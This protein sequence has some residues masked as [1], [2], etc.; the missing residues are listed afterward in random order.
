MKLKSKILLALFALSLMVSGTAISAFADDT[1]LEMSEN[2]AAL[3]DHSKVLEYFEAGYYLNADFNGELTKDTAL[4]DSDENFNASWHTTADVS[5]TGT[6]ASWSGLGNTNFDFTSDNSASFGINASFRLDSQ[7]SILKLSLHDRDYSDTSELKT[8]TLVSF[9][10]GAISVY[11]STY[12]TKEYPVNIAVGAYFSFTAFYNAENGEFQVYINGSETPYTTNIGAFKYT[13]AN[14]RSNNVSADYLEMYK[15]SFIR[16]LSGNDGIIANKILELTSLYN[17]DPSA[18]GAYSYL[19]IITK[20]VVYHSF[21]IDSLADDVKAD[22]KAAADAAIK[23]NAVDYAN[24]FLNSVIIDKNAPYN[25]RLALVDNYA[26]LNDVL[27]EVLSNEKFENALAEYSNVEQLKALVV[28]FEQEIQDLATDAQNTKIAVEALFSV[29]DV[30]LANYAELRE[31]YDVITLHPLNPTYYDDVLTEEDVARAVK[32]V[33]ALNVEFTNKDSK[34]KNFVGNM[35]IAID[36]SKPFGERYDAYLVAKNNVFVD[37]SYDAY[38]EGATV[39]E[40]YDAYLAM[41]DSMEQTAYYCDA[42]ISKVSLASKMSSFSVKKSVLDEAAEY[43]IY[44]N[45]TFPGMEDALALYNAIR[46]EIKEK[47]EVTIKYIEAVIAVRNAE[48]YEAKKAAIAIAKAYELD[49]SD[50]SVGNAFVTVGDEVIDVTKANIILSDEES[51]IILLDTRATNYVAAVEAI[52]SAEGM[53]ARRAAINRALKLKANIES[54]AEDI[55]AATAILDAAVEA[56]NADVQTLNSGAN[57]CNKLAAAVLTRSI[58][59]K[60][61]AEVAAIIKKF[62]E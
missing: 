42:F 53:V 62:Y 8:I 52:A 33:N 27:S 59:A 6:T 36:E 51:V 56:Y 50:V 44:I 43:I 25:T 58:P 16:N 35:L 7:D 2:S 15:G 47:I 60:R 40:L 29:E 31:V 11:D 14:L 37:S 54:E 23:V 3:A 34:A 17:S 5:F 38:I 39:S 26:Y 41:V 22:V 55:L 13:V 28:S 49:G 32:I 20:I 45:E 9:K 1:A 21:D 61:V 46:T 48:G 4:L 18:E 57:D 30:Y 19:E 24:E 10:E 12:G